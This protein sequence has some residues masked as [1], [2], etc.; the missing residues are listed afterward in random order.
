MLTACVLLKS[1]PADGSAVECDVSFNADQLPKARLQRM[2]CDICPQYPKLLRLVKLWAK[3][4]DINN[5]KAY[6][7]NSHCLSLLVRCTGRWMDSGCLPLLCA[8]S[9]PQV[10]HWRMPPHNMRFTACLCIFSGRVLSAAAGPA[11]PSAADL[12]R[13]S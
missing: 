3:A 6:T 5:A 12:Q 9:C 1:L 2:L 13:P 8:G 10:V 4:H 11:A 7:M